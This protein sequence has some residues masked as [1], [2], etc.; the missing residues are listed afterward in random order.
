MGRVKKYENN[1]EAKIAQKE[2]IRKS[3]QKYQAERKEFRSKV[4]PEQL[5]LVKLLNKNV[6]KDE[7]YLQSTL[8][9]IR[10]YIK[11]GKENEQKEEPKEKEKVEEEKKKEEKPKRKYT[12]RKL[13][14]ELKVEPK[15]EP[16]AEPEKK[17]KEKL[18]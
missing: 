8:S 18:K 3:N 2:Q 13:K 7:K 4:F 17:P 11:E 6:I 12:P 9:T 5:E 14:V 16:K 10:Q 15:T 1:E